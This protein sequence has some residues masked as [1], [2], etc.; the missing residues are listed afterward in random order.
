VISGTAF[1]V[2]VTAL[3]VYGHIAIGYLGTVT[4][5]SGDSDPGVTLPAG[6]VFTAGDQGVHTFAGGFTFITTGDQ[7]LTVT[8]TTDG[9]ITTTIL[10]TVS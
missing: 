7:T 8:D 10:V 9:T 2:T 6:Y 1:D 5:S 3:D 4:F